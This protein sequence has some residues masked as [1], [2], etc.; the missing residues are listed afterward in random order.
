LEWLLERVTP[1]AIALEYW[2][3]VVQAREQILRLDQLIAQFNAVQSQT[4]VFQR[5]APP[6]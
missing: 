2:K 4:V 1:K 5:L 6:T 3:D